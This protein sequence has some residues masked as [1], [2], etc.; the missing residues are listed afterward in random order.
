VGDPAA[1]AHLIFHEKLRGRPLLRI[2]VRSRHQQQLQGFIIL[3]P[4]RCPLS[5]LRS[6]S[7]AAATAAAAAA[8]AAAARWRALRRPASTAPRRWR[9]LHRTSG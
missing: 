2:L 5:L 4:Q 9:Q 7:R 1:P 6:A 3:L 8:D